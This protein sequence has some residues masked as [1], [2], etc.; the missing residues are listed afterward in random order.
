MCLSLVSFQE[1]PSHGAGWIA[2]FVKDVIDH[3]TLQAFCRR[4]C[5]RNLWIFVRN[6]DEIHLTAL[7]VITRLF[8]SD[9]GDAVAVSVIWL[10]YPLLESQIISF[11]WKVSAIRLSVTDWF[12]M[13]GECLFSW[14]SSDLSLLSMAVGEW[15]ATQNGC[16]RCFCI[17]CSRLVRPH[18]YQ[19][20][21]KPYCHPKVPTGLLHSTSS[22]CCRNWA[23]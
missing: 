14:L 10:A 1:L 20:Y 22:V 6:S 21:G 18:R 7:T 12:E 9:S 2:H 13:K 8:S 5:Q 17:R 11:S 3:R 23:V 4:R 15:T 16:S 19:V